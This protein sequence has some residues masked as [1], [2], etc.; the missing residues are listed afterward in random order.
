MAR[1]IGSS[2]VAETST[3]TVPVHSAPRP[4]RRIVAFDGLRGIAAL[5]VLFH[6]TLLVLPD[7]ANYEWYGAGQPAHGAI[8]WLLL[9]TPL[10][11][12][13][14]G[15]ERALLFFV[16]SG[17]VLGIPWLDGRGASYGRFLAGRFCRLYPPYLVAMAA[18][19]IGS[20]L[21]GGHALPRASIY[22]N[23]L[24]WAFRPSWRAIPSIVLLLNNPHSEY[25]NEAMWS[26]VW[27]VRVALIFPLLILPVVRWRNLGVLFV[28]AG[29][30]VLG[31]VAWLVYRVPVH[32]VL[33]A[34]QDTFRYAEY[35]VLGAAVA[36]NRASIGA[37]FS[38]RGSTPGLA[39]LLLG[40]LV[41]WLP[42]PAQHDRMVGLG[43]A[44]ILVAVLGS[45]RLRAWLV[46][47]WLLWLGRRSYSLY[48]THVPLVMVVVIA[49]GGAVP[50]L[51]CC[52]IVPAAVILA[53]LFHRWVELPSVGLA[54]HLG[55]YSRLARTGRD[56]C[57]AAA[58]PAE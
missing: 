53:G 34:P 28:L 58:A 46:R 15:Q 47:P 55:G 10:R 54:Q 43:A 21:L 57:A 31:H 33:G 25:M 18:A 48:L 40:C 19:A 37:W 50:V 3:L 45:A 51:A 16:L 2:K 44:L 27:E 12:M 52:A 39:C 42:W 29:L 26:L 17:F 41:C 38:R 6:H 32:G 13:W 14:A 9:R 24:G 30:L 49:F 8:E 22:F 4:V 1:P 20:I 5:L 23:E 56:A 35:F 11:L 36:V 7:F